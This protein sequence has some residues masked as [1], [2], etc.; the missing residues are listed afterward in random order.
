VRRSVTTALA[1]TACVA[2][3]MAQHP[4]TAE[5]DGR[6]PSATLAG[7][8]RLATTPIPRR[9]CTEL[10]YAEFLRQFALPGL[11]VI[12]TG[13]GEHWPAR[14]RWSSL[15]ALEERGLAGAEVVQ[16][17][18][19]RAGVAT[20]PL[21]R[22]FAVLR[23]RRAERKHQRQQHR[24]EM[25]QRQPPPPHCQRDGSDRHAAGSHQAPRSVTIPP[26]EAGL[27][28]GCK[29]RRLTAA[30]SSATRDDNNHLLSG[31]DPLY[32]RNWRFHEHNPAL[33]EDFHVP[34][35]FAHDFAVQ[36][37]LISRHSFTWMY[38]GEEGSS[39]PTHVDIM[40]SSAWLCVRNLHQERRSNHTSHVIPS[41][42]NDCPLQLLASA[43]N[44][45]RA[46]YH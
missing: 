21:Q 6:P 41:T 8:H 35:Y 27:T 29:R 30:S 26:Y 40:N 7:A 38:I 23:A 25:Q 18:V 19:G 28:S 44:G 13:L 17:Q 43:G 9:C 11:P 34:K 15:D 2:V 39:T 10:S 1:T 33:L 4:A 37:G 5:A 24:A 12:I 36:S 31:N 3:D 32:L 45:E 14:R 16:L 42:C 22:C 46:H 20:L